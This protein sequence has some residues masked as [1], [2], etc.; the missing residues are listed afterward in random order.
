MVRGKEEQ[1]ERRKNQVGQSVNESTNP[2]R[3][4]REDKRT[5]NNT[6]ERIPLNQTFLVKT[7]VLGCK[8]PTPT[9]QV[10]LKAAGFLQQALDKVDGKVGGK[11]VGKEVHKVVRV[12][13]PG[14]H[15]EGHRVRLGS[16]GTNRIRM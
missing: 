8:G 1:V 5:T 10:V 2:R 4:R 11:R 14:V 12:V 9:S 15:K 13:G 16:H 7:N 3:R 6:S